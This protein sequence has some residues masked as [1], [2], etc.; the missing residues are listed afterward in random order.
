MGWT[1]DELTRSLLSVQE[2]ADGV[3]GDRVV[4]LTP[5]WQPNGYAVAVY[6]YDESAK[7]LVDP[8]PDCEPVMDFLMAKFANEDWNE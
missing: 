3:L 8:S 4:E 7:Y 2:R 1:F 5:E 6:V